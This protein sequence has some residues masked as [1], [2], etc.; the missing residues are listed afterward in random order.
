VVED[1]L[2]NVFDQEVAVAPFSGGVAV[3][4]AVGGG[5]ADT[6][7][8]HINDELGMGRP[9]ELELDDGADYPS[10]D[11]HGVIGIR[12]AVSV[13]LGAD[14]AVPGGYRHASVYLSAAAIRRT[15]K[16]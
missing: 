6:A 10:V 15:S 12:H 3:R 9:G 5:E 2:P 7:G 1:E 11:G 16:Y 13:T 8:R 4:G 14:I